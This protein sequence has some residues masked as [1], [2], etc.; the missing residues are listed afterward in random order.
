MRSSPSLRAEFSKFGPF[1]FILLASLSLSSHAATSPVVVTVT[2]KV[3]IETLA[4][5]GSVT[6]VSEV[7]PGAKYTWVSTDGTNLVLADASG[8]HYEVA[9]TATDYNPAA[10]AP[11][12]APVATPAPATIAPSPTPTVA[13]S[14]PS[15][16]APAPVTTPAPAPAPAAGNVTLTQNFAANDTAPD[17]GPNVIVFDPTTGDANIQSKTQEI[18]GQEERNQFGPERYAFLFKP[19][20]YNA[21][22]NVGFYTQIYGLG[23]SPD[24][25][26]INGELK[27]SGDWN[28]GNGTCNFWRGVENLAIV[29]SG[30]HETWAVSQAAPFRRVHVKGTLYLFEGGWTSGGYM[31]DCKIDERVV[32]GSQQ[33]WYTRN[34]QWGEWDGGVWNMEFQ[35]V[36]S[37]PSGTWPKRP[38]TTIDQ[39]PVI[40]E[41]P[42]LVF[43]DGKYSVFVPAAKKDS[44]G[45]DWDG[46]QAG[47]SI[48]LSQFY[49]ARSDRDTAATMNAALAAGK[50]LLLTPGVYNLDTALKVTRPDTVV[51][52]IGMPTL[53]PQKGTAGMEISDVSGVKVACILFDA[54]QVESPEL[55]QVGEP[56]SNQ[57]HANDPTS[58]DDIFC[59][60]GGAA[61]GVSKTGVIINSNDVIGDHAW[62]WRADHGSGVGWDENKSTNGL[63]VNGRNVTY[64]GLFVEHFQQ[65]QV[66]WNGENGRT[67]FFQC[68]MPYDP[69][70][71]EA[72]MHGTVKGYPGYKVADN[73]KSHEAWGLGIYCVFNHDNIYSDNAVEAPQ[74]SDVKFHHVLIFRLSGATEQSGINSV[75]N[76]QGS[77]A[78]KQQTKQMVLEYP[79]DNTAAE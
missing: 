75:I 51:L 57:S 48:P 40:S 36:Q 17:F 73:V 33:Q 77:P 63:I 58:L 5:D 19:G 52:G 43:A 68:E 45:I 46:A 10:A 29:P 4:A 18:F 70:T 69:P 78:T 6:G 21:R 72:W 30:S 7:A 56:G 28:G 65:D 23:K 53:S 74:S 62:I 1:F 20:T 14:T 9:T 8:A 41:K 35:G 34:S 67:Y 49:I 22:I 44:A 27:S 15:A 2:K 31:A 64:Y 11:P 13:A 55:L 38:Y 32:S 71:Q 37:P 16:P 39:T 59:R 79:Q 50:N 12:P 76:G 47:T 25:T 60:I 54:G 42:F 26:T 24:D 61:V 66:L 3:P